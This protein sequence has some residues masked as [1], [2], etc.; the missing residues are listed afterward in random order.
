MIKTLS[1]RN[2]PGLS[3]CILSGITQ[4][5]VRHGETRLHQEKG[6]RL[7]AEVGG[8]MDVKECQHRPY[9]ET[10]SSWARGAQHCSYFY[11]SSRILSWIS[12]FQTDDEFLVTLV[13]MFVVTTWSTLCNCGGKK[14]KIEMERNLIR[15]AVAPSSDARILLYLLLSLCVPEGKGSPVQCHSY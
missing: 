11:H 10:W 3:I 14:S 13:P 15:T 5:P 8:H 12:Y 7:E 9:C 6:R 4:V 2:C 1:G